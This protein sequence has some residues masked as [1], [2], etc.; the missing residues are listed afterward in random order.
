ML[1][2][3]PESYSIRYDILEYVN[4][5]L[6]RSEIF[7]SSY[8]LHTPFLEHILLSNAEKHVIAISFFFKAVRRGFYYVQLP[9]SASIIV[10]L[11]LPW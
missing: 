7:V 8:C 4:I 6:N 2:P 11:H 3:G 5:F 10:R 9:G 1:L